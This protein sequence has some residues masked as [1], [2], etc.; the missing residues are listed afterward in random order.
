M[1]NVKIPFLLRVTVDAKPVAHFLN[2]LPNLG[3]TR[4]HS[5]DTVGDF[6]P[7]SCDILIG[8]VLCKTLKWKVGHEPAHVS[9]ELRNLEVP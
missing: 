9:D 5:S 7:H 2:M 3:V 1:T 8:N 6:P 4:R